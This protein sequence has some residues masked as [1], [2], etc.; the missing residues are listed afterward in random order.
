MLYY[1][2]NLSRTCCKGL[3]TKIHVGL[4]TGYLH[5]SCLSSANQVDLKVFDV[6]WQKGSWKGI[7]SIIADKGY[8]C[9][10]VRQL[11]RKQGKTPVIPWRQDAALPGTINTELY[12]TRSAIERFFAQVK[13]HKRLALRFDKLDSTFF[14][15]FALATIKILNLLC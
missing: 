7:Q 15:F 4:S 1:C 10:D 2:N 12:K 8:D 5:S 9:G 13:E 3:G 6:L 14:S 11:I